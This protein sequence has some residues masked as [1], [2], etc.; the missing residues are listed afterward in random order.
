MTKNQTKNIVE[1]WKKFLLEENNKNKEINSL[2]MFIKENLPTIITRTNPDILDEGSLHLEC[3]DGNHRLGIFSRFINC[4]QAEITDATFPALIISDDDDIYIKLIK[5]EYPKC[6]EIDK[7]NVGSLKINDDSKEII[8]R[9]KDKILFY[10]KNL[11]LKDITSGANKPSPA[12][13]NYILSLFEDFKS[14]HKES[15][16]TLKHLEDLNIYNGTQIDDQGIHNINFS[17]DDV[18]D[19]QIVL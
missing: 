1:N 15:Q 10:V 18:E 13:N 17:Y 11:S 8:S 19:F 3:L 14:K 9:N 2:F 4:K 7:S 12:I 6:L 16:L 5:E